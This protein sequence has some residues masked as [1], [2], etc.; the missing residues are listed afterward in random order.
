[1]NLVMQNSYTQT[2]SKTY[3]EGNV[4]VSTGTFR[5]SWFGCN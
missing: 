4:R 5:N 2:L 1:M 3:I